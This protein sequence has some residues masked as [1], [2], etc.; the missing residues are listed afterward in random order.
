MDL[1]VFSYLLPKN[2]GTVL[3]NKILQKT[4]MVK[5]VLPIIYFSNENNLI[6]ERFSKKTLSLAMYN[7]KL[8]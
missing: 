8:K 4:S 7:P 6:A 1:N 3:D 2:P 5:V